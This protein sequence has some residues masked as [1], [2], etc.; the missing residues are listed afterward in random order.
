MS[1]YKVPLHSL[2]TVQTCCVTGLV[3]LLRKKPPQLSALADFFVRTLQAHLLR[4]DVHNVLIWDNDNHNVVFERVSSHEGRL[5]QRTCLENVFD[6]LWGD[7]LSLTELEDV[8]LAIDEFE[9]VAF[10]YHANVSSV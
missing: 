7:V 6:L 10:D 9:R 5:N 4:D 3:H 2:K 1:H 8:L